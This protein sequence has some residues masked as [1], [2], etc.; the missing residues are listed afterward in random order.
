MQHYAV[1]EERTKAWIDQIIEDVQRKRDERMS[2]NQAPYPNFFTSNLH[3]ESDG[4]RERQSAI[5]VEVQLEKIVDEV[6][7]EQILNA[8]QQRCYNIFLNGLRSLARRETMVMT[9][10][11]KQ[12]HV[13]W[14][15]WRDWKIESDSSIGHLVQPHWLSCEARCL[16]H[17]RNCCESHSWKHHSLGLSSQQ[18]QSC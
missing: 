8:A 7:R 10:K 3:Q 12:M 2:P 18:G 6:A 9:T 16:R 13:S 15:F 17:H 1:A 4:H 14:R 5:A 11:F